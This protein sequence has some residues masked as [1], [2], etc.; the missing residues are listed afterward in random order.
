LGDLD[1]VGGDVLGQVVRVEAD[2]AADL[3]IGDAAFEHQPAHMLR[4]G[5]QSFGRLLCGQQLVRRR[6]LLMLR[7]LIVPLG[8]PAAAPGTSRR[9]QGQPAL[10]LGRM[11]GPDR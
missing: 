6:S 7:W 8:H 1:P 10:T 11:A 2:E 3:A 9:R 5:A 4:R